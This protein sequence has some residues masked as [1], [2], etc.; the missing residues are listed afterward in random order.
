[1]RESRLRPRVLAS[2]M[3]FKVKFSGPADRDLELI[4]LFLAESYITFGESADAA[5]DQAEARTLAMRAEI[6]RLAEAPYRGTLHDKLTPGLRHVTIGRAIVWFKILE[7]TQ[8]VTV[9]AVFFGAQDHVRRMM[10]RL[11]EHPSE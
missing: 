11:L 9:L 6:E 2:T 7:D 1:M 10:T 3:A 4:L 8:L 5:V